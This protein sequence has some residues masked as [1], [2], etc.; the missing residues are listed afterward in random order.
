MESMIEPQLQR[1][2]LIETE[3]ESQ[4]VMELMTG[5]V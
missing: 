1:W 3:M 5:M 2:K 4:K